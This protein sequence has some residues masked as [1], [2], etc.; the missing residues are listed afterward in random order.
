MDCT[1]L[2][3]NVLNISLVLG[4]TSNIIE[5]HIHF[6]VIIEELHISFLCSLKFGQ[7]IFGTWTKSPYDKTKKFWL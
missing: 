2:N 3:V 5:L 7:K 1:F 6:S 4:K